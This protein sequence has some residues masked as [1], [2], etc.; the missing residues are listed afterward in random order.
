MKYEKDIQNTNLDSFDSL[1]ASSAVGN[2]HIP[3]IYY[4]EREGFNYFI[5]ASPDVI[6]TDDG[7]TISLFGN[8]LYYFTNDDYNLIDGNGVTYEYVDGVTPN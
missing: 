5:V 4:T 7:W 6:Q 8:E 2:N 3:G 1:S